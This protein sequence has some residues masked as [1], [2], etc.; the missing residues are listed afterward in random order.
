MSAVD[1]LAEMAERIAELEQDSALLDALERMVLGSGEHTG[2]DL[3]AA[4]RAAMEA[5]GSE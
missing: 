4:I 3:R 5:S 2:P 1:Q